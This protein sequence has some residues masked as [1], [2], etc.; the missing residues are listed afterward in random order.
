MR[1]EIIDSLVE[2]GLDSAIVF[3]THGVLSGPAMDRINSNPHIKE[4]VVS[5]SLPQDLNKT[6]SPKLRVV[7]IAEL[8]GRAIDGILTGRSI[9]RLFV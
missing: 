6:L 3:V 7:S 9:S 5:D 4:V 8:L 2:N 1:L